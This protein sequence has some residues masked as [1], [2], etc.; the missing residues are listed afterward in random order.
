VWFSIVGPSVMTFE[1]YVDGVN[2]SVAADAANDTGV[3]TAATGTST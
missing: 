2:C 1:T 3:D